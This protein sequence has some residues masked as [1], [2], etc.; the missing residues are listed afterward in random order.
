L[1]QK[2]GGSGVPTSP[3]H[4]Q[5]RLAILVL[6]S[7][8]SNEP[9]LASTSGTMSCHGRPPA[10]A[11]LFSRPQ[12]TSGHSALDFQ[13][14]AARPNRVLRAVLDAAAAPT[15]AAGRQGAAERHVRR[16]A[17]QDRHQQRHCRDAH[18]HTC[19]HRPSH[20]QTSIGHRT[21]RSRS[22]RNAHAPLQPA[23]PGVIGPRSPVART[24]P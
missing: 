12:P 16:H 1:P 15:D 20:S 7:V 2:S 22:T 3:P 21:V 19:L 5:K 11:L 4:L 6:V 24:F 13:S 14:G 8:A 9:V 17:D 10:R 18:H 23:A